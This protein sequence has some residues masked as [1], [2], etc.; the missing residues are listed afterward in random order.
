MASVLYGNN[1]RTVADNSE[2]LIRVYRSSGPKN[3]WTYSVGRLWASVSIHSF[4][5]LSLEAIHRFLL[6][7]SL[8]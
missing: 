7:V 1:L 2:L 5:V 4:A 6:R 3:T 8:H